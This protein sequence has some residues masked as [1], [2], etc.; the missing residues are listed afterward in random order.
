[1]AA[2][3]PPARPPSPRGAGE[4]EAG[5]TARVFGRRIG[6]PLRPG[7]KQALGAL[8]PWL[9]FR[10]EEPGFLSGEVVLEIGFGSG[11]HFAGLLRTHSGARLIGAEVFLN[12]LAALLA[13][14]VR[15]EAEVPFRDRT[16][17]W[18]DDARALLA[19]LPDGC[20][21]RVF[22][23]FPDPWPKSRHAGRRMV[24]PAF[25]GDLARV[26]KPHG[27]VT[28]ATD[29]PG[30]RDWI[31]AV[32]AEATALR[33]VA[34][35]DRRPADPPRTRY[36]AKAFREGRHTTWWQLARPEAR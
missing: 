10:P 19:R 23:L 33:V 18:P 6:R 36:E 11:E 34:R 32:L 14:L 31:A 25:L 4:G 16:R 12:G 7:Q 27:A 35:E 30:Y 26:L 5:A 29:H 15:E 13:R 3:E 28:V 22:L 24:Q 21:D 17:L 2:P 20:L 8:L 9:R 1:M